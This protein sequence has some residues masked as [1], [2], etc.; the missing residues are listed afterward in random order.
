M[1]QSTTPIA[2]EVKQFRELMVNFDNKNSHEWAEQVENWLVKT[3]ASAVSRERSRWIPIVVSL[4]EQFGYCTK[5]AGIERIGTGGLGALED[6]FDELAVYIKAIETGL[7]SN[8]I[9]NWRLSALDNI[10]LI[11]NSDA[12]SLQKIGREANIFQFKNED[13]VTYKEIMRIIQEGD[14]KK[15]L[16]TVEFY[17]EEGKYY[18][19]GHRDCKFFCSPEETKKLKGLCPKCNKPLIIGVL[20]RVVELADRT[21]SQA[22]KVNKIPYK[23]I[24]PLVEILAGVLDKGVST[25][26]V[27]KEYNNLIDKIGNEFS[28]LLDTKIEEIE[29]VS[30]DKIAKAVDKVRK[31][32]VILTSGFDGEFGEVHIK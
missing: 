31:G 4:V 19:D 2:D 3:L 13:E 1:T 8:P 23:S 6:A 15:F 32:E 30:G 7:S 5:R 18:A 22:K 20:N 29:K 14:K 9:M 21:E 24:V 11:S 28:I 12:H 10:T 25:K 27:Q 26:T 17:P 16:K